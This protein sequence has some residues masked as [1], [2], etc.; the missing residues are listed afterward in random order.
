MVWNLW[1]TA[2]QGSPV[3]DELAEAVPLK[4]ISGK[5]V[6]GEQWHTW[7]ERKT[8]LF[9]IL[10]FVAVAIGG[11]VEIVPM[12]LVKDNIPK[13][14]SVKPYSPLELEGRD[15]YM[16]EGCNNCHS[17]MIRPFRS[18]VERYGEYSKAGEYVNDHPFLWGSRRTGPD[19]WREGDPD[20]LGY[21]DAVWHFRHF[22]DPETVSPGTIMPR[23]SW[24]AENDIDYSSLESKMETLRTLGVP[25]TDADISGAVESLKTQANAVVSKLREDDSFVTDFGDQDYSNKEVIAVIAYL[26]RI[27][28]D[29]KAEK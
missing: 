6:K 24:F 23:Y 11:L 16:R 19:L 18:E 20:R 25:Y 27:G 22:F 21:K 3:E 5:R 15:V 8:V 4:A 29:I 10:A 7:L 14:D 17:Q 9:T 2:K 1:K 13:I 12:F 26:Q 28:M